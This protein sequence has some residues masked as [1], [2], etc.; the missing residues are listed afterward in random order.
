MHV[1]SAKAEGRDNRDK[2][3]EEP[4]LCRGSHWRLGFC[5][6]GEFNGIFVDGH[7]KVKARTTSNLFLSAEIGSGPWPSGDQF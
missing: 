7:V 6:D 4:H 2:H 3:V 5:A 1:Y